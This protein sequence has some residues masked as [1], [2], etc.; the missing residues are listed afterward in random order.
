MQSVLFAPGTTAPFAYWINA[1]LTCSSDYRCKI[2]AAP[3]KHRFPVSPQKC[4]SN[5]APLHI[6]YN[7]TKRTKMPKI[8]TCNKLFDCGVECRFCWNCCVHFVHK[9]DGYSFCLSTVAFKKIIVVSFSSLLIF[10][11][12][13]LLI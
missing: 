7:A 11:L 10:F 13:H 5:R 3:E 12:G 8:G 6:K 9:I 2:P 4:S 1:V